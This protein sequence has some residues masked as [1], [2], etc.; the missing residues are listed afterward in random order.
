M[1]PIAYQ[2]MVKPRGPVCNLNC[3]YCY[4]LSKEKLYPGSKFRLDEVLLEEF[5]RQ[6]L[7]SQEIPEAT[8]AWQGGEPLLMGIEFFQK[9]VALQRQYARPGMQVINALQTNGTLLDDEW[10]KFFAENNF[11][12]GI[13]MDGPG[14]LHDRYRVDRSGKVSFEKVMTGLELL[15]KHGVEHNALVCI[16]AANAEHPLD[17]YHFFRD[18][19]EIEFLQFIPIVERDNE[20]G[21]QE[22]EKITG[23]SVTGKKYGEFLISVFDEWVRR[24]VGSVFVQIFDVSLAAWFGQRPALCIFEEICGTALVLEHNGDLYSCDHFVE[25]R[26]RLGNILETPMVDMVISGRQRKF[27]SDKRDRLPR[28]CRECDVRF[29]CNGGCPKNR[30]LSTPDGEPGLN[31]L[32]E[33]YKAFFTHIDPAMRF[34]AGELKAGRPPAN[35]MYQLPGASIW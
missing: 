2:V 34:M 4:Y 12:I 20:T 10:C 22:G 19:V 17:V 13:S 3:S 26:F 24:D 11:L 29:V 25:P 8:V 23:R 9:A 16:H 30:V 6:Y 31:W 35:I 18:E 33:G 15:Q 1:D 28:Y 27:G 7:E 21:F 14:K 5:T 32:C